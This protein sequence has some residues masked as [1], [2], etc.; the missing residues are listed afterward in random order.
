VDPVGLELVE[1]VEPVGLVAAVRS[2]V[3]REVA[4]HVMTYRPGSVPTGGRQLCQLLEPA[5][6]T[7]DALAVL[8]VAEARLDGVL[9]CAYARPLV[10]RQG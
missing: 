5:R 10:P 1:L 3:E 4:A 8:H 6:L 2:D 9:L 7:A